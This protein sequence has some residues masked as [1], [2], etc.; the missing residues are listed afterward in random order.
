[1]TMETPPIEYQLSRYLADTRFEDLPHEVVQYCKQ[2]II[3]SLGVSIPGSLAP[4]CKEVAA[5]AD[6]WGGGQGATIMVSG[7]K[8]S[9]PLAALANSTMM[10]ALD[11]DDTLDAS[12]LHTFVNILPAVLAA[13]ETKDKVTGPE[14]ITSIVLGVDIICRLSLA[15]SRPLSW[16][17]TAT[18]GGFGAA[19]A[20]GKLLNLDVG[21]MANAL[22]IVYSQTAGNAQGLVE[23]RLVKRLQPGFA[24]QAGVTSAFLAQKGITGSQA[25]LTGEYG[26]YSLYERGEY[27]PEPV[28][29]ALGDHYAI[30]DLSIK[31]YPACRMTHSSIDAALELRSGL[32]DS[33]GN[34]DRLDDIQKI[35]VIGSSMVKEMVGK[36]FKPGSTP[37]V[38]AQFSIPYTVATA[39]L[40]GEVFLDHFEAGAIS[41][42]SV[43]ALADKIHVIASQD[44]AA[45]DIF[46]ARMKMT[47]KD[48]EIREAT[49]N[50]PLGN[51]ARPMD[52]A[53]CREKFKRCIDFSGLKFDQDRQETLLNRVENLEKMDNVQEILEL[54]TL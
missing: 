38:D 47:F 36:P 51:P 35:Q 41:D 42:S 1:M 32:L 34:L 49:V 10:H 26:F 23:G 27:D 44:L 3:D 18:C 48:G 11:F 2:M 19:A 12:A 6:Q 31:P 39:L 46:N 5:L 45:K 43:K 50:I 15:I 21:Q 8:T 13:A 17:R 54:M 29:R 37:Q 14:L 9:P 25:F 4:G 20:V 53:M 28:T 33:A 24:A 40:K 52:M 16:I 22:G 30:L 7:H